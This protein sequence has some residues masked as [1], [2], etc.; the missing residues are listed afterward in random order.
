VYR[1]TPASSDYHIG[2]FA[3][4]SFGLLLESKE[5]LS[6]MM[7]GWVEPSKVSFADC[8]QCRR[9]DTYHTSTWLADYVGV[10]T[11]PLSRSEV[12]KKYSDRAVLFGLSSFDWLQGVAG[13]QCFRDN[14][15]ANHICSA[16]PFFCLGHA[17]TFRRFIAYFPF[18]A[19]IP[20]RLG[21]ADRWDPIPWQGLYPARFAQCFTALLRLIQVLPLLL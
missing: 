1:T 11:A 13:N 3:F 12:K 2:R 21:L 20:A 7:A 6:L 16:T 4:S 8:I 15:E 19:Q 10:M 14:L 18:P 5:F 9:E 17:A